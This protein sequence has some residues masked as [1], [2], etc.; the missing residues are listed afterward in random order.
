MPRY[1]FD[2]LYQTVF[3]PVEANLSAGPK[4]S[5]VD[6]LSPDSAGSIKAAAVN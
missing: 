2:K 3:G 4:R 1:A 5:L 6:Y